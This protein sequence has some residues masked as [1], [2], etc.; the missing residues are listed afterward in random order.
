MMSNKVRLALAV[1]MIGSL[2]ACKSGVKS[3]QSTSG[4]LGNQPNP[5]A[6][7]TVTVDPLNDPNSPL[8]KRSVYFDFD[9]YTVK[10][11]Y[12]SLLQAHAQYLKT[13]P[14]RHILIQGNTDER[15]TSEYN[16][17]L[18]QKRAEAV[19]Q[20]LLLLGVPDSQVEAVSLGKEK[21]VALG[22]DEASWAQNRRADIVYQQQ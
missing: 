8:A 13:H 7:T 2:A 5:N 10:D 20:A 22:H 16:L 3:D 19:R 1:L 15:G 11:D 21:P 6:V 4:T 12:Q 14:E 9:S 18:G 17:A